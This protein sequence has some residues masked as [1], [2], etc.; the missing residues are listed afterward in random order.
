MSSS[1][2][3]NVDTLDTSFAFSKAVFVKEIENCTN[4]EELKAVT[5]QL[6]QLYYAQKDLVTKLMLTPRSPIS[7]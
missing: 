3:R 1:E 4:L 5:V 7:F 2:I 6:V